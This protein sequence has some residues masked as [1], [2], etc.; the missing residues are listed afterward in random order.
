MI[1]EAVNTHMREALIEAVR[2]LFP[3]RVDPCVLVKS[4]LWGNR[5]YVGEINARVVVWRGWS[6]NLSVL[7]DSYRVVYINF[8]DN[9]LPIEDRQ[10]LFG[11]QFATRVQG[12]ASFVVVYVAGLNH[13]VSDIVE[14]SG[15]TVRLIGQKAHVCLIT[16]VDDLLCQAPLFWVSHIARLANLQRDLLSASNTTPIQTPSRHYSKRLADLGWEHEMG[17]LD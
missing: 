8:V 13:G 15:Y 1:P 7:D 3:I 16:S 6:A 4:H 10:H 5:T 9:I 17:L 11:D 12:M 14:K 2:I